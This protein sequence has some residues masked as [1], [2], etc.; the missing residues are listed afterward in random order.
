MK[1]VSWATLSEIKTFEEIC[2]ISGY[3]F[4]LDLFVFIPETHFLFGFSLR[5]VFIISLQRRSVES[6]ERL[7]ISN[8]KEN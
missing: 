7:D 3:I 8:S 6:G 4:M 1:T 2:K 5:N